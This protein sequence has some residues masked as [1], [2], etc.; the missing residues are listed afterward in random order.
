MRWGGWS[1]GLAASAGYCVGAIV[2]YALSRRMVFRPGWLHD[3]R[4][5]EFA[6]FV[7]TGLCGL[8]TTVAIV[9]VGSD[10]LLLPP[11]VS[12]AM[13]VVASFVAVYMLRAGLVFRT[14][15]A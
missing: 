9:H 5:A 8:A 3:A 15:R 13:A 10:M 4:L 6:A 7:A 11:A 2:H 14:R 1:A 12:K